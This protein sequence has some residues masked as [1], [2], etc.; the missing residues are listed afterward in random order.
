M[1]DD[2]DDDENAYAHEAGRNLSVP[3]FTGKYSFHKRDSHY[4]LI[5]LSFFF[6]GGGGGSSGL[7]R[8]ASHFKSR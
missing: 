7:W 4:S 5:L 2:D 3:F 1:H 8:E 6:W